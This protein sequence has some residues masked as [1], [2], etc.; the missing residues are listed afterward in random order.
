VNT[1][2]PAL[3]PL[4]DAGHHL[5]PEDMRVMFILATGHVLPSPG[6]RVS[7]RSRFGGRHTG[8]VDDVYATRRGIEARVEEDRTD[9]RP[10][11]TSH[12]LDV[13]DLTYHSGMAT[14]GRVA[15]MDGRLILTGGAR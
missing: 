2:N 8:T 10:H 13:D 11:K 9:D 15:G 3:K 14:V 7:W 6:D 12:F 4:L 5:A 1:A